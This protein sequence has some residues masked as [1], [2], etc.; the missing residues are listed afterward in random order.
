MLHNWVAS[1]LQLGL[2]CVSDICHLPCMKVNA[3]NKLINSQ[4]CKIGLKE[5]TCLVWRDQGPRH[6]TSSSTDGN[7]RW[8]QIPSQHRLI[9]LQS[10]E[11][12]LISFNKSL[13]VT[14]TDP[15]LQISHK[16]ASAA[17]RTCLV[18]DATPLRLSL[19]HLK[20]SFLPWINLVHTC[21]YK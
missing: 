14:S 5:I 7:R 19:M 15:I 4:I 11:D 21:C 9:L 2:S 10:P 18:N 6:G 17:Q 13:C 1:P 12:T 16:Q 20:R 8:T 3:A